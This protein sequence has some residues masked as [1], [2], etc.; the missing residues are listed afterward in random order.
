MKF[1]YLLVP[2]LMFSS[3]L[4]FLIAGETQKQ[5]KKAY[6]MRPTNE[7]LQARQA[8]ALAHFDKEHADD[9]KPIKVGVK[10]KR[11]SPGTTSLIDRSALLCSGRNWTIV[12]KR[13][14]LHIPAQYQARVNG[15]RSGKLIP[16]KTFYEQNR[17]WIHVHSVSM[18]EARGERPID[19]KKIEAYKGVSRVVISVCHGGPIS[20]VEPPKKDEEEAPEKDGLEIPLSVAVSVPSP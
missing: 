20:V 10:E 8:K 6:Q 12:P 16:W 19:S 15:K 5:E 18:Q 4:A 7:T 14:V 11:E 17:G 3:G 1:L 9:P 2:V 13:A